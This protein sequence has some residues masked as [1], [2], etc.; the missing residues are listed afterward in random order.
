MKKKIQG[1]ILFELFLSFSLSTVLFF[2]L[3]QIYLGVQSTLYY[4]GTESIFDIQKNITINNLSADIMEYIF[5]NNT[6]QFYKELFS[7]KDQNQYENKKRLE[8]LNYLYSI[9][10]FYFPNLEKTEHSINI[11]FISN[12]NLFGSKKHIT[13]IT[14]IFEKKTDILR[15]KE[16][17]SLFR[18]ETYYD[19]NHNLIKEG[20]KYLLIPIIVDLSIKYILPDISQLEH[21]KQNQPDKEKTSKFDLWINNKMYT[22]V[23]NYSLPSE[24]PN[25]QN[26]KDSFFKEI[27]LIPYTLHIKGNVYTQNF[28]KIKECEIFI[29][30]PNTD[31]YLELILNQDQFFQDTQKDNNIKNIPN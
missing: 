6:I 5:P 10:K 13:K 3:Y 31:N 1:F 14:Y 2:M 29:D 8:K 18:K 4:V 21:P 27:K 25:I 9:I 19:I 22:S 12:R 16:Y 26:K 17:Y 7:F 15:N 28:S 20:K 11:S 24:I 30:F 23:D